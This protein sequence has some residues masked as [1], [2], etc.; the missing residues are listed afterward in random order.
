MAKRNIY[1]KE[2]DIKVFEDAEAIG[3]DSISNIIVEA[4]NLY[5]AERK[6]TDQGFEKVVVNLGTK[7]YGTS[8]TKKVYFNG[9][10]LSGFEYVDD[11]N[12]YYNISIY[13]TIKDKILIYQNQSYIGKQ[14][15]I[16][17]YYIYNSLE[18]AQKQ[19]YIPKNIYQEAIKAL[20]NESMIYLDV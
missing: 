8:K 17:E 9:K 4:L 13:V 19:H 2:K 10:Y 14:K 20:E 16:Y 1:V 5:I 6:M 11:K 15:D 7:E 3:K 18:E 12:S